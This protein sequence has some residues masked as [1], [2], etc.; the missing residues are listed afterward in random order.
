ML[1][2]AVTSFEFIISLIGL[3]RLLHPLAGITSQLQGLGVDIIEPYDNV[4]SVIKDTK[5][6]MKNIDKEFNVIFE[7]AERVAAKVRTQAQ[8]SKIN[9]STETIL[10]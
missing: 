5:S 3:Y 4:S 2:N 9:K 10:S 1:L 7:R 6:T 8:H